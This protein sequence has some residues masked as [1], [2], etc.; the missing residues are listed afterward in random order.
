MKRFLFCFAVLLLVCLPSCVEEYPEPLYDPL[1]NTGEARKKVSTEVN[2]GVFY[3]FYNDMTA[4]ASYYDPELLGSDTV[5]PESINGYRVTRI[6]DEC[7]RGSRLTEIVLPEGLEEIGERAFY[8]TSLSFVFFPDRLKTIGKEAFDNC[9]QLKK[10]SFGSGIEEIGTGAFY[11]TA[12]EEIDLSG[13]CKT[14]GEEAFAS[15]SNLKKLLLPDNLEEI[16]PYAFFSCTSEDLAIQIP[17][18]VKKIG[19]GA[20]HGTAFEKTLTQEW[21]ILGDGVL[22]RYNGTTPTP[23]IPAGVKYLACGFEGTAVNEI[24]LPDSLQGVC[25]VALERLKSKNLSFQGSDAIL[26][27]L[28]QGEVK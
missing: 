9:R 16:G 22:I 28:F 17:D 13:G 2:G 8:Q 5:I 23:I 19:Y 26:S 27:T 7:F 1:K 18:G 3:D 11:G 14:I 21:V 10:A 4:E 6:G 20:F 15:L 25:P 24:T 12:L